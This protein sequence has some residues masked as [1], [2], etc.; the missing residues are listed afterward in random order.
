MDQIITFYLTSHSEHLKVR[1]HGKQA[2]L[3]SPI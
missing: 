2:I 3:A 1:M